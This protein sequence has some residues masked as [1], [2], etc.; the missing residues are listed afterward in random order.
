MRVRV[1]NTGIHLARPKLQV[2]S[3]L[4]APPV[5]QRVVVLVHDVE[6]VVRLED[7]GVQVAFIKVDAGKGRHFFSS[8]ISTV[9][10]FYIKII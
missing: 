2:R 8:G 5:K 1:Q 4:D 6:L 9:Q 7:E 10:S 3:N